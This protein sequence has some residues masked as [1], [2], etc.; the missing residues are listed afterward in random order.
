[1]LNWNQNYRYT[2]D[3]LNCRCIMMVVKCRMY[4]YAWFSIHEYV[5]SLC[6]V[7]MPRRNS[8]VPVAVSISSAQ[9]L[10]SS[11]SFSTKRQ[12]S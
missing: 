6:P 12:G 1:M 11:F 10:A 3:G 5:F 2:T 4:V 9:I 8:D 7:E